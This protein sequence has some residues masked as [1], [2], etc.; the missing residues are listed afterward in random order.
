[1][2]RNQKAGI[3]LS[4]LWLVL[5]MVLSVAPGLVYAAADAKVVYGCAQCGFQQADKGDC[6]TC[7]A[8]LAKW[9]I[10]YECPS[11]GMRQ[12]QSGNCAMCGTALVEKKVPA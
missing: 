5:G 3:A 7:K 6:P 9:S 1:M 10:V 4:C 11:C 12:P 8:V 2:S